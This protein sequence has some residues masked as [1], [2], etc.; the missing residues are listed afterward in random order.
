MDAG[1]DPGGTFEAPVA[2]G[3]GTDT[4][5]AIGRDDDL[6]QV[7]L[8]RVDRTAAAI[9]G[10]IVAGSVMAAGAGHSTVGG[11]TLAVIVTVLVYWLAES[12]AHVLA[13]RLSGESPA[14]QAHLRQHLRSTATLVTASFTPLGAMLVA[15]AFGAGARDAITAALIV[16]SIWL[17]VLGWVAARRSGQHGL[18]LV[19]STVGSSLIGLVLIALKFT[20]H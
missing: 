20:L 4:G 8:V 14:H 19:A 18:A 3:P 2:P 11:T 13:T 9:Y 7:V 16:T 10:T 17:G 6:E 15:A 1:A 5:T 12:Y